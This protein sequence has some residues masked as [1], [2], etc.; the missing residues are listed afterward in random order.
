[1]HRRLEDVEHLAD[2]LVLRASIIPHP[3]SLGRFYGGW[4][5]G[6]PRRRPGDRGMCVALSL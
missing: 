1:M 3:P 6:P 4:G 5:R 2:G